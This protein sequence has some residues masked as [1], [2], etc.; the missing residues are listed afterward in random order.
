MAAS[1]SCRT[2][3]VSGAGDKGAD[4]AGH[5]LRELLGWRFNGEEAL[6]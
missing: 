4:Q 1:K 2:S 6:G 3:R 5:A